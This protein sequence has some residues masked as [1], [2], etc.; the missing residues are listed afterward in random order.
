MRH[1]HF[2]LDEWR[3]WRSSA[4]V[5]IPGVVLSLIAAALVAVT[6]GTASASNKAHS[7]KGNLVKNGHFEE[8]LSGWKS[9]NETVLTRVPQGHTGN[10]SVRLGTRKDGGTPVLND[11]PN[12]VASAAAGHT[13][14]ARMWV[15]TTTSP[16]QVNLRVREA[17]GGKIVDRSQQYT[18]LTDNAWHRVV[19]E[20]TAK[21]AGAV[22]DLNVL[23][24]GM[25]GDQVL[26]V[27]DVRLFD[28]GVLKAG[29]GVSA[30]P[31]PQPAAPTSQP[32]PAA[33][34]SQPSAK[35]SAVPTTLPSNSA[36]AGTSAQ[37]TADD[38]TL[39][40]ACVWEN[41]GESYADALTRERAQFG[42]LQVIRV[43][44]ADGTPLTSWTSSQ[45]NSKVPMQVSFKGDPATVISGTQDAK[46]LAWFKAAPRDRDI[47]WT[48]FHEP[49]DNISAG[50]FTAAQYVAA[51]RHLKILA[52]E[53]NNPHLLATLSLM[54]WSIYPES[55]RTWKD[56]YPGNDVIDVLAWDLNNLGSPRGVYEDP[57][58]L[59]DPVIAASKSVGK[60][61]A[62]AEWGSALLAG[63]TGAKRAAWMKA[64]G[65]YMNTHGALYATYFNSTVGGESRLLDQPSMD[66]LRYLITH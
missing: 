19:V 58:K 13:Y 51:W 23:S 11:Q 44:L 16:M 22:L 12:T 18:Y 41:S 28:R 21:Q 55:G 4:P 33:P 54:N 64:M 42:P 57:A 53:A 60:P 36:P 49:D 30:T 61:W 6:V 31:Q 9:E 47:Y 25:R 48:F 59:L 29:P 34:T 63:D 26:L 35:P 38:S 20:L 7:Y 39:F 3:G 40:G 15:K 27:D 46:Y 56:M 17:I 5:L 1:G 32:Q 62:L 10:W 65:A 14:R 66:A 2:R 37:P 45:L 50:Q 43:Y 52:N 8:G 24:Y